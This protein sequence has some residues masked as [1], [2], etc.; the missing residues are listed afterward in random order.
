MKILWIIS[1]CLYYKYLYIFL[2][3]EFEEE[4]KVNHKEGKV[5]KAKANGEE[6]VKTEKEE[7]A[8]VA[9]RTKTKGLTEEIDSSLNL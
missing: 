3:E 9:R 8:K 5:Q 1:K 7:N 4:E 6:K 2:K